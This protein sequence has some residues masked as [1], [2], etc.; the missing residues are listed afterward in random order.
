MITSIV[1]TVVTAS[2]SF[3]LTQSVNAKLSRMTSNGY[4]AMERHVGNQLTGGKKKNRDECTIVKSGS[5][6][7]AKEKQDLPIH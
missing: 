1:A 4:I 5:Q 7:K 3:I 6:I 2:S